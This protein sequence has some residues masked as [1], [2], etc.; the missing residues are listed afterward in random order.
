MIKRLEE[1]P[2]VQ[3]AAPIIRTFGLVNVSN[4]FR[5]GVEVMGYPPDIQ[6]VN[7]FRDSLYRIKGNLRGMLVDKSGLPQ[8]EKEHGKG[9]R[10]LAYL[11]QH[12][13]AVPNDAAEYA[14]VTVD[15]DYA[16]GSQG[17]Q[18]ARL[19]LR[20]V[21]RVSVKAAIDDAGNVRVTNGDEIAIEA[22]G[23]TDQ[24]HGNVQGVL[25]EKK[26]VAELRSANEKLPGMLRY[27]R[28]SPPAIRP[29]ADA[30]AIVTDTAIYTV[31]GQGTGMASDYLRRQTS[32]LLD[33]AVLATADADENV[34]VSPDNEIGVQ[35]ISPASQLDYDLWPDHLYF[36]P[37]RFKGDATK[38]RGIIVGYGVIGL[39]KDDHGNVLRFPAIYD[40]F[41]DVS[42]LPIDPDSPRVDISN[43]SAR[44]F[45]WIIDD[46][47]TRVS[48]FDTNMVYV[49][50]DALQ[51]LL[52][53]DGS[54]GRPPRTSDIQIRL[55][56]GQDA[57]SLRGRIETAINEV[58]F[59]TGVVKKTEYDALKADAARNEREITEFKAK[60]DKQAYERALANKR[61]YEQRLESFF[62]YR[63]QSWEQVHA[64]FLGQVEKE[65]GLVTILFAMISVVAIFLIFCIFYMIV[66]EKTRNI[67]IVKSVGATSR[68]VAGIFLGYGLT[69]GLIGSGMGLLGG[70]LLVRNINQLHTWLGKVGIVLWNPELYLFEE[71]PHRLLPLDTAVIMIVAV[72]ASTLGALIPAMRA[73]RMHP[74]EALRWE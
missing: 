39:K 5:K 42:V 43:L 63:V 7:G 1:M 51:Q 66:V 6:K 3:S 67:G 60:G 14:I 62:P 9:A 17:N 22:I 12:R 18:L 55:K 69:I 49:P 24:I 71:I 70:W 29:S 73:A 53:M 46:S 33:A 48:L 56:A 4:Q 15:S 20:K 30:Y 31:G 72:V 28:T 52:Q 23:R 37:D 64:S 25:V 34:H 50:F 13:P 32:D 19:Y 65:T 44:E 54:D 11:K 47:R 45:F 74:V 8:L 21:T 38:W 40:A 26:L 10:L 16:L 41:V 2:E 27:L 57:F 59:A 68:G 58:A 61:W 35:A 36:N